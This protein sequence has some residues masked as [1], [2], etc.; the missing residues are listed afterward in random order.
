MSSNN[1]NRP[2]FVTVKLA[3]AWQ[4]FVDKTIRTFITKGKPQEQSIERALD[5]RDQHIR[6]GDSPPKYGRKK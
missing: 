4:P 1:P 2:K 5:L 3:H 6:E